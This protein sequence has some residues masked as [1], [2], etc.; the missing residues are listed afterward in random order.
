MIK[1]YEKPGCGKC[2]VTITQLTTHGV[3]VITEMVDPSDDEK[4]QM[5]RDKGYTSFP[6]VE[7]PD[8]SWCDFQT[9]K[10]QETIQKYGK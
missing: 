4:M 6:V 1:V 8:G 10:I 7:T 3:P 5:L 2:A 9:E